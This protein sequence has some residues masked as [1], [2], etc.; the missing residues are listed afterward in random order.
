MIAQKL[1]LAPCQTDSVN[2]NKEFKMP[3]KSKNSLLELDI[4]VLPFSYHPYIEIYVDSEYYNRQ[5]FINQSG[6]VYLTLAHIPPNAKVLLKAHGLTMNNEQANL[7]SFEAPNLEKRTLFVAP[8]P[9]DI[10]ISCM[11]LGLAID[12]KYLVTVSAGEHLS[13][14]SKQYFSNLEDDLEQAQLHK[15][16]IRALNA[17]SIPRLYGVSVDHN[18]MLGYPDQ[19]IPEML[20]DMSKTV[21]KV[22]TL[23]RFRIFNDEEVELILPDVDD[24]NGDNLLN[25][26]VTILENIQPE[27]IVL[28]HPILDTHPVH[29]AVSILMQRAIELSES[30]P[31]TVITYANHYKRPFTVEL[32]YTQTLASCLMGS[33]PTDTPQQFFSLELSE[34]EQ[35]TKFYALASHMDL[36]QIPKLFKRIKNFLCA[37][38][39][40]VDYYHSN[41]YLMHAVKTNECFLWMNTAQYLELCKVA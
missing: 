28:P 35:Q 13:S 26:L 20:K 38:Y 31:D 21:G 12:D 15:G 4:K 30:K 16:V 37:E 9:D 11:S 39:Y 32:G 23:K 14:L 41:R 40:N 27:C 22:Q 36:Q 33:I 18:I 19:Q 2:P 24:V 8:H 25:D 7:L 5:F 6:R 1:N 10:E 3:E 29:R 17:N 34:V